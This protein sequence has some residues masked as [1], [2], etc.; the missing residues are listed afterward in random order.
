MEP[1]PLLSP[2]KAYIV[3]QLLTRD[4]TARDL[5]SVL[6]IQV[7]A[8]RRHLDGLQALGLVA[9]RFERAPR[10][11]PRKMYGLTEAGRELLPRR[12]DAVLNAVLKGL[13]AER[14]EAAAEGFL[15]RV[16]QGI[17]GEARTGSRRGTRYDAALSLLNGLGFESS[18]KREDDRLR[19]TSRNCPVLKAARAHRELVCR[20]LHAEI[21]R[22]AFGGPVRRDKWIVDGDTVCTHILPARTVSELDGAAGDATRVLHAGSP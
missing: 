21:L 5:A 15:N 16:A 18:L 10:G 17:V 6:R 8:A 20:G 2:T 19:V 1:L 11:R 4:R 3:R 13:V 14:G 22:T 7:S 12:Y 9:N